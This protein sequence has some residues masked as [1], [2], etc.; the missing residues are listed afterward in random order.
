[1]DK[2]V[3]TIFYQFD[4]WKPSIGGIQTIIHSFI[5]YAPPEF[6]VRLVGIGSSNRFE[7][8]QWHS[9]NLA[10][11][12]IQFMP[13]FNVDGDDT[14]RRIPTSLRY[15]TALFNKNL[16]SDFI[17]FHRIEP[18]LASLLWPGHKTL[19]VHND[20]HQQ[21]EASPNSAILW[22]RF[23]QV[24]FAFERFLLQQFSQILSCNSKSTELYRQRY[25]KVAKRVSFIRNSFDSE[26][27]YP[28][29]EDRTASERK[30]FS[31]KLKLPADTPFVLFAGRLHPQKD[32]LLLVRAI[33]HLKTSKAHLLVAGDGELAPQVK[34]EAARLG[35]S[36]R[37]TLLGSVD[38]N[39]LANLHRISSVVA[40]SSAYEGMPLVVLEALAC[41][42]PVVTTLAGETHRILNQQCG[43][44]CPERTPTA[45]A[46]TLDKVLQNPASYPS[47]A[48]T[49]A[50]SAFSASNI[51]QSLYKTM[52]QTWKHQSSV[53]ASTQLIAE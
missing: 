14:R 30:A 16:A 38:R 29:S 41:G 3:L 23:P 19:F 8:G 20:I 37:L 34:A 35:I 11:K 10:G 12:T 39:A 26:I 46:N 42:T 17:H 36:D 25:P 51:I 2:P 53:A 28:L 24:Y 44:I 5:K 50:V 1:M 13:L 49:E 4:P 31:Q 33:A 27:F 48:C 43:E 21:I 15:T 45:L 6:V 40:L 18:S 7:P 32:P 22:Q 9:A 47:H 52:Y